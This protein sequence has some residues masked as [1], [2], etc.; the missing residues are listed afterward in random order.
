MLWK[1]LEDL[2]DIWPIAH[3]HAEHDQQNDRDVAAI[4]GHMLSSLSD[5]K[6]P[7]LAAG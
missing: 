4:S 6:Q 5:A 1:L 3:A 2:I 7:H